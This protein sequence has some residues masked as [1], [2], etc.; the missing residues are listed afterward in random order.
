MKKIPLIYLIPAGIAAVFAVLVFFQLTSGLESRV[1]DGF[2]GLRPSPAQDKNIVLVEVD[3]QA[4]SEVG[5]WPISRS[6]TADGLFLLKEMGARYAVFDIEYLNKS[7]RG[8]NAS[9]LEETLPALLNQGLGKLAENNA[10]IVEALRTR[11]FPLSDAQTLAEQFRQVSEATS[12]ELIATLGKIAIDND[13]TLARS[14]EIFGRAFLTVNIQTQPDS[15]V[16]AG[17]R[18]TAI[19]RF[20]LKNLT[21]IDH[22]KP[23]AEISPVIEPML[24]AAKG[25]GFTNV[26]ID[27]AD[28]VRRRID[29]VKRYGEVTFPQLAFAPY[30]DLVGNPAVTVANDSILIQGAVYPDG[31]TYNVRVPRAQDGSILIN[32]PHTKFLDSFRHLSFYYL[33]SHDA[34]WNDLVHNLEIRSTWGY[35]DQY[36]GDTPLVTQAEGLNL[37]RT[38]LME[39]EAP[40][41]AIADFRA[42]RDQFLKDLGDFFGTDPDKDLLDQLD[43][44]LADPDLPPGQRQDYET[45]RKD[46][47]EW[48]DHTRGVYE[49]LMKYRTDPRGLAGLEGAICFLGNTNTGSTD[50]GVTPFESGYA[51][52]GTHASV[53]NMLLQR[54][55]VTDASP[56][57]SWL[58]GLVGALALAYFLK[59][60]KPVVSLSVGAGVSVA[61]VGVFAV[62]FIA[63]GL[64]LPVIPMAGLIV[65]SFFGTTFFQFLNTE[66]EKGFLRSA[67]SRY[68]SNDV[69]EQIIANPGQLKLGGQE[70]VLTAVFTDIKGFSTISEK[71]TPEELVFLLNQYL[72][73]MSDIIL[74][75]QGTIDKYEG[76]AIIA[77]FG[78]P[79]SFDDHARRAC[80]AAVRMKRLE[81][82]LNARFLEERIA[83]APLAT[84][85]GIN[86]GPMVVGNMGTDRMMNYTMIGDAVNLAARLEGVN[87][88]YGTWVLISEDTMKA[89]GDVIVTRKLDRVRVVGKSVP[90]RLY[91]AVEEKGKLPDGVATLLSRY[92]EALDHFEARRWSAAKAGFDE[93]LKLFPDDGPSV[94]YRK[95][96]ADYETTP[97]PEN[98]DG[99]FKMDQ[100]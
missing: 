84:R 100:K 41:E 64:Y 56:W 7:P 38:D 8:V 68:L 89:A 92:H 49:A 19:G 47:P 66:K 3:D 69:I 25:V 95:L 55:F 52:L 16:P 65:F 74:D 87:K 91:Q 45:I 63:T 79:V 86:T 72:T 22:L 21:G 27:A 4:V 37:L 54:D 23:Y 60:K 24:S 2:L 30:L 28:G 96:A 78:A 10:G 71:M 35:L 34:L 58:I 81:D 11:R 18:E 43:Q 73:G 50:L 93:C 31:K 32:W 46:L 67:F 62:V 98:W 88:L 39:G 99:V 80:L 53:M 40:V 83:P 42:G 12:K 9:A 57:W 61:A 94:R 29:L 1:Y 44:V 82:Q 6:I 48:F 97:P 33:Y 20:S 90:I 26:T 77:F 59:G 51:N 75:L 36:A 17:L 15:S 70:K 13:K 76:D 5:T 85:I 14:A